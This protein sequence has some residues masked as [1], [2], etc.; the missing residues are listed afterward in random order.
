MKY[1]LMFLLLLTSFAALKAQGSLPE[2]EQ[3][4]IQCSPGLY[5][6]FNDFIYN[7]PIDFDRVET[8]FEKFIN[9]VNNNKTITIIDGNTSHE[10][11]R[12]DVWGYSDGNDV[13]LNRALFSRNFKLGANGFKM[14]AT[15]W[16]KVV[17]IETLTL[18][19]FASSVNTALYSTTALSNFILNT[20]DG[21]FYDADAKVLKELIADDSDLL[22]EFNNDRGNKQ[23]RVFRFLNMYNQRHPFRFR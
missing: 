6:S 17:T 23:T 1:S 12:D 16:V 18:I 13:Y 14:Q 7:D 3:Q 9:D 19:G 11:K 8:D 22:A 20:K 2:S 4:R 5:L 10:I 21:Q 15:P